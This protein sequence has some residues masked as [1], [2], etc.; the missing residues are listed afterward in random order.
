[1]TETSGSSANPFAGLAIPGGTGGAVDPR[2]M[3]PEFEMHYGEVGKFG[4]KVAG[5]GQYLADTGGRIK[6]IH[7]PPLTFSLMG[8]ALNGVHSQVRDQTADAV[9]KGK[10]VLESCKAALDQ[11][12][13]NAKE[14]EKQ[15]SGGTGDGANGLKGGGIGPKGLG[16][17]GGLGGG[18]PKGGSGLGGDFT[19]PEDALGA[20]PGSGL[21]QPD[22]PGTGGLPGSGEN[23][24]L[25]GAGGPDGGGLGGNGLDK[26]ALGRTSLD[27][28]GGNGANALETPKLNAPGDTSL[29]A[30]NPNL[31]TMPSTLTAPATPGIGTAG[32]GPGEYPTG[33]RSVTG[34][35][36]AAGYGPG[37]YATG[38]GTGTGG[39]GAGGIAGMPYAPMMGPGA[40]DQK[41]ENPR[42]AAEPEPE[43]TWFGDVD[44]APPVLGAQED[45]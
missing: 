17:L 21:E 22:L 20:K 23:G 10:D 18:L 30:H 26:D 44:V 31:P 27:G 29:S 14:A 1:M 16:G 38:G 7:L 34:G 41:S 9:V 39:A 32:Y 24:G 35:Y 13:K 33:T 19:L 5:Q 42:G 28:L 45:V 25:P 4:D 43:S 12:I 8:G 40:G 11:A 37:A 15:S 2:L 3:D 36:G 6:K